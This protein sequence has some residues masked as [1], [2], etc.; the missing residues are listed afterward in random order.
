MIARSCLVAGVCLIGVLCNGVQ[1]TVVVGRYYFEEDELVE[2]VLSFRGQGMYDGSGY[3]NPVLSPDNITDTGPISAP[4]TYLQTANF[5]GYSDVSMA[6]DF[7][8]TRVINRRGA[9]IA[10][11]FLSDQ[12]NNEVN[13]VI[14]AHLKPLSFVDVFEGGGVQQVINGEL[15]NWE[16]YNDIRLMVAEVELDDYGFAADQILTDPLSVEMIQKDA[17]IPVSLSMVGAVNSAVIPV[18][19]AIWLFG[20][21]MIGLIVLA[22]RRLWL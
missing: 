11:F 10:F 12:T 17:E 19:A 18:P 1:A 8:R 3:V 6:L 5:E 22:R 15:S 4:L 13:L 21:G 7:G 2:R 9:D 20:S 16:K 14:G